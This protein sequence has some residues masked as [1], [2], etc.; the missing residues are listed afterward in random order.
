MTYRQRNKNKHRGIKVILTIFV[1]LLVLR[2]FNNSLVT[3]IFDAPVNYILKSNAVVISPLKHTLVYFKDKQDLESRVAAL[4]EENINLKLETLFNRTISQEFNY[5]VSQFG[6][7]TPATSFYKVILKPPFTPFD[8]I[9]IAGQLSNKQVGD[10]VFYKN[11]LIGKIV[12]K[13]NSYAT[14]ELFSTPNKSTPVVVN[15]TQFEAKGLGGGRYVFETSKEFELKEGDPVVYPEQTILVL[16]V[17][18]FI[19]TREED[20]FRKVYFNLPVTL[21]TISYVTVGI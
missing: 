18:E 19:E 13:N 20:L 5:F 8:N 17:V 2:F 12:E 15:G 14:V 3:R 16:G 6:T 21:D 10:F 4:E 11:I 1:L 7:T 9:R